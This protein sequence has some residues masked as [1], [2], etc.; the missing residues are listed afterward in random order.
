[1][2]SQQQA[3]VAPWHVKYPA[4]ERQPGSMTREQL[5]ELMRQVGGVAGADFVLGDLR[6]NDYEGGTIRGSI[7]LPAQSLYP[8]IPTLYGM[9][10]ARG[11][12]KIIW[13]CCE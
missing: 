9:F 1:M 11:L 8:S 6:R 4:P 7:N 13:Y 5:L 2:A 10:K 3:G 12:R